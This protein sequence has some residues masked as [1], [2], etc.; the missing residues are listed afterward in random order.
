MGKYVSQLDLENALSASSVAYIYT[1]P[2]SS[3]VNVGALA[4][5]VERAEAEVDSWMLPE[6]AVEWMIVPP[7]PVPS[8]WM[9]QLPISVEDTFGC[10][11]IYTS[12]TVQCGLVQPVGINAA[13]AF[14]AF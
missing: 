2:G 12:G 14:H 10:P 1:D 6:V 11:G 8:Y 3:V 5:N 13:A 9:S 7:S 4:L